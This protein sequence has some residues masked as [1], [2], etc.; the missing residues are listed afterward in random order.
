[1]TRLVGIDHGA[2]RIG[3]AV[4]DTE[5][6]MAFARGVLRT[7]RRA[8]AIDELV[9]LASSEGAERFVLGLPLH[10]DG[11]EGDQAAAAREFGLA[12]A[13]ASN[14][15]VSLV[16]ERLTSWQAGEE[17]SAAGRHPGRRSGELDAAAARLI[18]QQYLDDLAGRGSAG[19][20]PTPD[21]EEPA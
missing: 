5:T 4:G 13:Q 20:H 10:A 7:R 2:R 17:L 12:L 9:R 6:G 8:A 11:S 15:P 18:L 19:I 3:L 21:S 16:D 1:V 14:L